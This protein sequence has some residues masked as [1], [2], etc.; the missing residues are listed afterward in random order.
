MENEYDRLKS[1]LGWE[2]ELFDFHGGL[3]EKFI[4]TDQKIHAMFKR[5]RR[6]ISSYPKVK[7][8]INLTTEKHVV[9]KRG[10]VIHEGKEQDIRKFILPSIIPSN[11]PD[12]LRPL[13][14]P[15]PRIPDPIDPPPPKLPWD[16]VGPAAYYEI[17]PSGNGNI[18]DRC[19]EMAGRVYFGGDYEEGVTAPPF[20]PNCGCTT[21]EWREW[22][23]PE[24]VMPSLEDVLDEIQQAGEIIGIR[25]DERGQRKEVAINVISHDGVISFTS[26]A[27]S[28]DDGV[29]TEEQRAN[30]SRYHQDTLSNGWRINPYD[31]PYVVL[32]YESGNQTFLN[33][34]IKLGDVV[35]VVYGDKIVYGLYIDNGPSDRIG[36][37]SMRIQ[38][39]LFGN[40]NPMVGHDEYDVTYIV[41][42]G[43]GSLRQSEASYEAIQEIGERLWNE[44][45]N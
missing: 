39:E 21:R 3:L 12:L 22:E 37:V 18:C 31:I 7:E 36:E 14:E 2:F 32:P 40:S 25:Y 34:G 26:L 8:C 13:I 42:P 35:A 10:Y 1:A 16:F 4:L 23:M 20:H 44:R 29:L 41:F 19:A 11:L 5:E 45:F 43:S 17:V 6:I 38:H 30:S 24:N 9:T 28:C 33:Q 27:R 15:E